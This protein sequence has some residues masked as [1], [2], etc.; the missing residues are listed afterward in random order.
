MNITNN[1]LINMKDMKY[2]VN[3]SLTPQRGSVMIA[4]K[5]YP[6]M[7]VS[8][9]WRILT[10]ILRNVNVNCT[11]IVNAYPL[12]QTASRFKAVNWAATLEFGTNNSVVTYSQY[13]LLGSD[14]SVEGSSGVWTKDV[15]TDEIVL[16]LSK[17]VATNALKEIALYSQFYNTADGVL[18]IMLARVVPDTP[19][20]M[21][22]TVD[23][24]LKIQK[25]WLNNFGELLYGV[26]RGQNASMKDSAGATMTAR[27]VTTGP[28]IGGPLRLWV[29]T[30]AVAQTWTD[31][32][33]TTPQRMTETYTHILDTNNTS[34]VVSGFYKPVASVTITEIGVS[35]YIYDTASILHDVL[36]VRYVLPTPISVP[37]GEAFTASVQI[38]S[39]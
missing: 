7:L 34:L 32:A 12:L 27:M 24:R 13:A 11:D 37:A 29:G 16:S 39:P 35:T 20:T 18:T 28:I 1:E 6:N 10:G 36:L 23:Y 38:T 33:L 22:Q 9:Y 25:P 31:F 30:G 15:L 21:G 4:G 8:N 19:P 26:I 2:D 17:T 5:L 3:I 14:D